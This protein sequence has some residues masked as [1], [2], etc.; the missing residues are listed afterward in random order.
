MK[1]TWETH[2]R[3]KRSSQSSRTCRFVSP[4]GAARSPSRTR[5]AQ[6]TA[7]RTDAWHSSF[8]TEHVSRACGRSWPTCTSTGRDIIS[9][10][11]CIWSSR[12]KSWRSIGDCWWTSASSRPSGTVSPSTRLRIPAASCPT[13][14][15]SSFTML[16]WSPRTT[17]S[18][19]HAIPSRL[20][21]SPWLLANS[22]TSI[23][24]YLIMF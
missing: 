22:N 20:F 10:T 9:P 7:Y 2:W 18:T 19:T 11:A 14:I 1:S 8:R 24:R 3:T 13:G 4:M 12:A 5:T 16:T 21:T 17:V 6:H 23:K 15:V